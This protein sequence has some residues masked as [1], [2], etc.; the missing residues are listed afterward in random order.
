MS[1]SIILNPASAVTACALL[2]LSVVCFAILAYAISIHRLLRDIGSDSQAPPDYRYLFSHI[3]ELF[4]SWSVTINHQSSHRKQLYRM[5]V[6]GKYDELLTLL[7]SRNQIDAE[8]NAFYSAFDRIFL[9]IYPDFADR[10]SEMLTA[11]LK[12]S[13]SRLTA[14]MRVIAMIKLGIDNT[15]EIASVLCYTPQTVYNLRSSFRSKL[16]V[17]EPEFFRRLNLF[18]PIVEE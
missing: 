8:I 5:A 7:K 10:V 11:P 13:D 14:E 12:I 1:C 2:L 4:R 3:R 9:D 16:A 15:A 17:D 18:T 6:T